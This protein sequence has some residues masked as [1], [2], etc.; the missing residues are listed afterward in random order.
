MPKADPPTDFEIYAADIAEK[1]ASIRER[2]ELSRWKLE[3][4]ALLTLNA[5][6]SSVFFTLWNQAKESGLTIRLTCG[7]AAAVF[8]FAVIALPIGELIYLGAETLLLRVRQIL[9]LPRDLEDRNVIFRAIWKAILQTVC[10]F[11]WWGSAMWLSQY[12]KSGSPG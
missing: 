12:V 9:N 8:A 6:V 2:V 3:L 10:V 7:I 11:M 5:V 1:D 4:V